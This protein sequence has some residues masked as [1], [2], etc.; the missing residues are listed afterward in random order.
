MPNLI[1]Q[2]K[3]TLEIIINLN[4]R[5]SKPNAKSDTR[6]NNINIIREKNTATA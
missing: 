6:A 1:F 2:T 4:L 5:I 3:L